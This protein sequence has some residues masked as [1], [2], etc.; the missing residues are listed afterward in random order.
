[1]TFGPVPKT[2][3]RKPDSSLVFENKNHTFLLIGALFIVL[4]FTA[5]YLEGQYE[6]FISLTVSPVVILA[7]YGLVGYGILW[8]PDPDKKYSDME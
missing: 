1:M 7:G 3:K 4:G 8:R 5:M 6:G 2:P